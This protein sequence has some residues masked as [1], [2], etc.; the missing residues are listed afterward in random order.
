MSCGR[1][2]AAALRGIIAWRGCYFDFILLFF[3]RCPPSAANNDILYQFQ[4][5]C[6]L[7]FKMLQHTVFPQIRHKELTLYQ[8]RAP[9]LILSG[10]GKVTSLKSSLLIGRAPNAR[11]SRTTQDQTQ[12]TSGCRSSPRHGFIVPIN[13]DIKLIVLVLIPLENYE[14]RF[15]III[16]LSKHT[17][18]KQTYRLNEAPKNIFLKQKSKSRENEL[19]G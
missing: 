13:Q 16:L 1:D 11:T 9:L 6:K 5:A 4:S 12:H 7:P 2:E 8:R 3:S 15:K 14:R 18:K 10:R 19:L 17:R